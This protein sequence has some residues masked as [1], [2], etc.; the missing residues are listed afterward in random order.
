MSIQVL[1]FHNLGGLAD[2]DLE[3]RETK[4]EKYGAYHK[5]NIVF[6]LDLTSDMM[7]ESHLKEKNHGSV[8]LAYAC[9]LA[10]R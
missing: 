5:T 3:S 6:M 8:P 10:I 4:Y 9:L 1:N 2:E 7:R